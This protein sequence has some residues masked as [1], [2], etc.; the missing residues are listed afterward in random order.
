MPLP[1]AA[2]LFAAHLFSRHYPSDLTCKP[3]SDGPRLILKCTFH[4]KNG[5]YV[6]F[7]DPSPEPKT[8][9]PGKRKLIET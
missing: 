9:L 8:C 6:F 4:A 1:L 3:F 7:V 5:T 2:V